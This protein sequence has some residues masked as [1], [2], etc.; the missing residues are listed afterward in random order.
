[1]HSI[2]HEHGPVNPEGREVMGGML[3]VT[4]E[5]NVTVASRDFF[6]LNL[7][8]RATLVG[9]ITAKNEP[10]R[11]VNEAIIRSL[12]NRFVEETGMSI[13]LKVFVAALFGAGFAHWDQHS[14][15]VD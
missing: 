1:M 10:G 2:H 7:D 11:R 4:E 6:L 8:E 5:G 9:W 15:E 14:N 12:H 13:A 3:W